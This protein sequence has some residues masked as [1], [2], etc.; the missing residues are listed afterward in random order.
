MSC[1][2]TGTHLGGGGIGIGESSGGS[3]VEEVEVEV[4]VWFLL[5][6]K[7]IQKRTH[8]KRRD[9]AVMYNTGKR[10]YEL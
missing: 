1:S 3:G 9:T 5:V 10:K 8:Y 6:R 4:K 2:D 7:R